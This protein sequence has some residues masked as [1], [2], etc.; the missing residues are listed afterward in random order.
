MNGSRSLVPG[1]L[2]M[3]GI[4]LTENCTSSSS[5]RPGP[6]LHYICAWVR[7]Q[8]PGSAA[9]YSNNIAGDFIWAI[10][11]LGDGILRCDKP[12]REAALGLKDGALR[13]WALRRRLLVRIL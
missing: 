11:F 7:G 10:R 6:W 5:T 9:S 12:E 13:G 1:R 2:L 8:C 3:A 4:N